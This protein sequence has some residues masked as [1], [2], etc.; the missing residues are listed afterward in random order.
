VAT[1]KKNNS[2][3]DTR[4]WLKPLTQAFDERKITI[5]G[6]VTD[7]DDK[8]LQDVLVEIKNDH[9]ETLYKTLSN[10]KGEY[11][12]Q[13]EKGLYFALMA[14]K[15]YKTR[16]LEYWVWNVPAYRDLQFEPRIGQ[17]EVY[18]MNAFKPQGAYPSLILYF[19]PMSLTRYQN[20][21]GKT[22]A[23]VSSIDISPHL[24]K[25][26]IE[27]KVNGKP[28]EILELNKVREY[29]G[30]ATSIVAYLL[31]LTLPRKSLIAYL[32]Q[33]AAHVKIPEKTYSG[34]YRIDV[35]LKDKQTGDRGEGCL[36]WTKKQIRAIP[37][38]PI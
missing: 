36:F 26:D 37:T 23:N 17:I 15:D 35:A 34:Y 3:E 4:E 30:G 21:G 28:T 9:F 18:A 20:L 10:A 33:L 6:K 14:C 8:P 11:K 2:K 29:A 19:R 27:V 16:Y 13:V 25:D 7:F 12:M 32:V 38:Q 1:A 31:Q 22:P 24:E 5:S